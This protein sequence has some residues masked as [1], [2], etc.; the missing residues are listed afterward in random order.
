MATR[1]VHNSGVCSEVAPP[2]EVDCGELTTVF[3]P[4]VSFWSQHGADDSG[5]LLR[6][7]FWNMGQGVAQFTVN[8][9]V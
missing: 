1:V 8:L 2:C 6:W 7:S 4:D 3:R 5:A 9:L